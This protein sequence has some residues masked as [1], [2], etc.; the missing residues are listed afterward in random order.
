MIFWLVDAFGPAEIDSTRKN[1]HQH[2][3][4]AFWAAADA[5]FDSEKTVDTTI[6]AFDLNVE[7]HLR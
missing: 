1:N 7:R 5:D 2:N 4:T 6:K 3:T